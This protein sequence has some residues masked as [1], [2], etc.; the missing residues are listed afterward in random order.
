VLAYQFISG[1]RR[2]I[3]KPS[4]DKVIAFLGTCN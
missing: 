1:I 2:S 4:P 3:S